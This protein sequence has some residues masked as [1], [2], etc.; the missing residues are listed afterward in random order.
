MVRQIWKTVGVLM[1]L[2]IMATNVSARDGEGRV[3]DLKGNDSGTVQVIAQPS[4]STVTAL[5]VSHGQATLLGQYTLVGKETIDTSTLAITNGVGTI[6]A[7]DG[8]E[9]FFSFTGQAQP[10]STPGML[11]SII[12][13]QI[14]GGTGRFENATGTLTLSALG[15]LSPPGNFTETLVG[16]ITLPQ[17]D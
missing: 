5:E 12:H 2:G 10:A 1:A 4:S 14:T 6:T 15:S 17:Q 13:G 8:S 9:I 16:E 3:F 7:A 11:T